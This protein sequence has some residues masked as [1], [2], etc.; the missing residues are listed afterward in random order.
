MRGFVIV[1]VCVCNVLQKSNHSFL[2]SSAAPLK[3]VKTAIEKG[4]ANNIYLTAFVSIL[5]MH[6]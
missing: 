2:N 3:F 6:I 1:C 4:E 5:Y